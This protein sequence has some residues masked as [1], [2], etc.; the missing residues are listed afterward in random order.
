VTAVAGSGKTTSLTHALK[1]VPRGCSVLAVA[2]NKK[3]AETLKT[4]VP[5][6]VDVATCHS[7]GL[8]TITKSLGRLQI[9]A[10]KT[11]KGFQAMYARGGNFSREQCRVVCKVVSLA[12]GTLAETDEELDNLIDEYGL[13]DDAEGVKRGDVIADSLALLD[14]A[15][16]DVKTIDFDDMIW[17][18]HVLALRPVTYDRVFVDETQDLNRAQLEL[19][20]KACTAFDGRILAVGDVRQAIYAFRWADKN[21]IPGIVERLEA[22]VLPLSVTYRCPRAVV[23]LVKDVAPELESAPNADEGIVRWVEHEELFAQ[24]RPGEFVLSRTNA[25]LIGGCLRL[26][27]EGRRAVV[28]GRDIGANLRGIVDRSKAR[29]VV[30]LEQYL[31]TWATN[32]TNRLLAK[33]PPQEAA[34]QL[35]ADKKDCI[36]ALAEG[37]C[38]IDEVLSRIEKLFSDTNDT[39]AVV[40]S[41]VHKSKGLERDKVWLLT[42]T[43][44]KGK[45]EEESN[46]WYVAC[47]RAHK[48]LVLVKK[49]AA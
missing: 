12:K 29:D 21:A 38:R 34:A 16:G 43:F 33:S 31:D 47:T 4:R 40:F 42:S 6:G 24:C 48:E 8:R 28:L 20:L 17:L 37:C 13:I 22:K 27:R 32:E 11:Y 30:E 15:K 35:V 36:S 39:N 7:F 14:Q 3:I 18:P 19:A 5:R 26:L 9:D 41:T 49:E 46:I 2:F 45:N 44:R 25:P 23:D 10:D 1:F